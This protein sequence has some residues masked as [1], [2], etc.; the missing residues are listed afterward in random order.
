MELGKAAT[1]GHTAMADKP[2]EWCHGCWMGDNTM[3]LF[4]E[5]SAQEAIK[6]TNLRK[7]STAKHGRTGERSRLLNIQITTELEHEAG[8][9]SM[10]ICDKACFSCTSIYTRRLNP[11]QFSTV[12]RSKVVRRPRQWLKLSYCPSTSPQVAT[13]FV[14]GQAPAKPFAVDGLVGVWPFSFCRG[15]RHEGMDAIGIRRPFAW[16]PASGHLRNSMASGGAFA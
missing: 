15:V 9:N 7:Q 4:G 6:R 2:E 10:S 13:V 16:P 8:L 11:L 5:P 14:K 1:E 12:L 3:R